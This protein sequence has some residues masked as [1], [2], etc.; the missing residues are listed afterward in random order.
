MMLSVVE[1][2]SNLMLTRLTLV[3]TLI[4]TKQQSTTTS[5]SKQIVAFSWHLCNSR[6]ARVE[7][8]IRAKRTNIR[9]KLPAKSNIFAWTKPKTLVGYS[10]DVTAGVKLTSQNITNK[11]V[12]FNINTEFS[13]DWFSKAVFSILGWLWLFGHKRNTH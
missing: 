2:G 5:F 1:K 7:S 6:D 3:A 11:V 9:K 8:H 12:Y 13:S 10:Q 4:D